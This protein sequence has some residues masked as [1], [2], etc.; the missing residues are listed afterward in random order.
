MLTKITLVIALC[1]NLSTQAIQKRMQSLESQN[2]NSKVTL[3]FDAK[4]QC[5]P[6]GTIVPSHK[7]RAKKLAS[8]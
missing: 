3:R 6:D 7:T 8:N 5:M 4:A 2:P 1:S